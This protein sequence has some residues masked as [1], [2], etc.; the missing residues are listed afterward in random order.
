MRN[1]VTLGLSVSPGAS[2]TAVD[3]LALALAV[4]VAIAAPAAAA[5][6]ARQILDRSKQLDDTV[7]KWTDRHQHMK[8]TIIDRRGGERRRELDFY[9]RKDPGDEQKAIVFFAAPAEV[10]GT[11][12]L[13]YTHKGRPADQWLYLPEL[14]RIRQITARTRSESFM[15]TDFTYHDLDLIAEMP[16][17]R[18]DD[19]RSSLRDSEPVD[20]V[21][22]NV[23]ELA[24]QRED[25]GYQRVV[26]WLGKE[27]LFARRIE[28]Y[29]ETAEPKKRINQR[30]V[31]SVGAVPVA[32]RVEVE[33]PSAGSRTTIEIT[34]VQLN[35]GI[36]ESL[37]TQRA[38]EHG[39]P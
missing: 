10:R 35:T 13:A 3:G 14:K 18:E 37:F 20:G 22:C 19:A 16:S 1:R 36:E 4:L 2:A 11:A 34:D 25:I 6:T 26:L 33:T 9:E 7:R 29:E 21:D 12:F 5:E 28:L 8:L 24:P 17:W 38:L 30:D 31:R 39:N 23:I 15:G 32:H 27:D